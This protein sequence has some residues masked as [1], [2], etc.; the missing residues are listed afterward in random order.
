MTGDRRQFK[1]PLTHVLFVI[2]IIAGTAGLVAVIVFIIYGDR[3]IAGDSGCLFNQITGLYCPGC[4]GTRAFYHAV[5]LHFI[6]SFLC[7]PIVMYSLAAYFVFM[8][9]TLLVKFTRKLGFPE[10]PVSVT[11]YIGVGILLGQWVI[12]NILVIFWGITVL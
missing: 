7:H 8:I 12:R 4:G 11:V 6:K 1:D 3:I 10:Y 9:N 5:H 2:G